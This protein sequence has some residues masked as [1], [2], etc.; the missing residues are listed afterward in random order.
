[1]YQY[2]LSF[3]K[4]GVKAGAGHNH[5]VEQCKIGRIWGGN[6]RL[7]GTK[8]NPLVYATEK[9][10]GDSHLMRISLVG[11]SLLR[12]FKTFQKYLAYALLYLLS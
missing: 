6:F 2:F 11:I 1:M 10:T 5:W 4:V 3:S 8:N 12:F 9:N 7:G